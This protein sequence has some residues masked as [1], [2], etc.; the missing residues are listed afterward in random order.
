MK[1][2][3]YLVVQTKDLSQNL[4]KFLDWVF[5]SYCDN[6]DYI[7]ANCQDRLRVPFRVELL[8]SSPTA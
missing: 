2:G 7:E 3:S 6:S 8:N 1:V 5:F 4:S